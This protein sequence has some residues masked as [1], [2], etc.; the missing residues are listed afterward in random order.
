MFEPIMKKVSGDGI[1][2]QLAFWGNKGKPILCIHGI[3]A[4]CRSWDCLAFALGADHRVIAMDLRGRGLSD[5]PPLGYSIE[6][7]CRDILV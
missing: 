4:N 5:K 6:H 2:I 3:T 1:K 7:H